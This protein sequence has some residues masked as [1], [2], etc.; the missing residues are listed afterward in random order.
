MPPHPPLPLI[1]LTNSHLL[2]LQLQCPRTH[3]FHY[4]GEPEEVFALVA[5]TLKR[6]LA[7]APAVPRN[8]ILDQT[9]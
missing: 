5:D 4:P 8:Y 1:T 2:P 9:Q 6:Q 3:R 7:R